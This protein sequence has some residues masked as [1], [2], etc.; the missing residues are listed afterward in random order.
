MNFLDIGINNFYG[1]QTLISSEISILKDS[2]ELLKYVYQ[3]LNI[4]DLYSAYRNSINLNYKKNNFNL[5]SES[6][7]SKTKSTEFNSNLLFSKSRMSYN[8][9]YIN[10]DLILNSEN[11]QNKNLE[12][13]LLEST[14]SF[15]E[16]ISSVSNKL[17]SVFIE[18]E[19]RKDYKILDFIKSHQ[20]NLNLDFNKFN[21]FKYNTNLKYRN[22]DYTV[23]SLKDENHLLSSNNF[24]ISLFN[25]FIQ[26]NKRYELGKGKQAKKEKSYIKVPSGMGTHNWID[27][28]NNGIQ[29]LNEFSPAVFQDGLEYVVLLLPSTS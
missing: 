9:K 2:I 18:I 19:R 7:L 10:L 14:N 5:F 22:L 26:L 1:N 28:N 4:G 16:I 21:Y 15:V 6:K 23:D 8:L 24:K 17:K 25:N 29:E 13:E 20:V 12:N 3:N 11:F 27:N